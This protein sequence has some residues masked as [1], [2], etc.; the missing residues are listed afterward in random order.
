MV[1]IQTYAAIYIHKCR[2]R[3]VVCLLLLTHNFYLFIEF[4]LEDKTK[5]EI[6]CLKYF[7]YC[8]C[9]SEENKKNCKQ[10]QELLYKSC[11]LLLSCVNGPTSQSLWDKNAREKNLSMKYFSFTTNKNLS[12]VYMCGCVCVCM[13]IVCIY[14]RM[15]IF[16]KCVIRQRVY[17]QTQDMNFHLGD[18]P[19][20]LYI[21]LRV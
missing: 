14:R 4:L 11:V 7:K 10:F 15:K 5:K 21:P 12:I 3:Y 9:T 16:E 1:C 20:R 2:S 6:E 17:N 13:C 18:R 8:L 19:K